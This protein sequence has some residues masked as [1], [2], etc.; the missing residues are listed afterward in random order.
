M[1]RSV[2]PEPRSQPI[3][4]HFPAVRTS[5]SPPRLAEVGETDLADQV[6]R[7]QARIGDPSEFPALV[8]LTSALNLPSTLV[9]LSHNGPVGAAPPVESRFPA[10]S[11]TPDGGW[12]V[13][14][15]LVFAHALQ[16]SRFRTD[17][18]SPAGAF[19]LMQV[20]PAAATDVG[21]RQG[22][23][24]S[25]ADLVRPSV[26]MEVG[27]SYL[28]QLRDLGCTQGLLPKVIAAYNAGPAPVQQWN[29]IVRDGGDPLLYIESIPYWET[30]G[31]VVTVMRNYWMY[32]GQTGRS[33]S[34]SR[35]A[36]AQGLWP[37][38]PGVSGAGAVRVGIP[39]T[40]P[41]PYIRQTAPVPAIPAATLPTAL[42]SAD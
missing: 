17:V 26:N 34:P 40:L 1:R 27:Q 7:Q 22:R 15:A 21:R 29:A 2:P 30:R 35:Q 5:G 9:W 11:W 32:E 4:W 36:M 14:R 24:Y 8:R 31:Y 33:I 3:G 6:I 16:E 19:G 20:V 25:R 39:G 38:F 12:R 28:E 13:D 23:S 10:P 41:A 42:A 37:R 18:V